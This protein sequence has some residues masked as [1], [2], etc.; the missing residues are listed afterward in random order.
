MTEHRVDVLLVEDDPG[1]VDLTREALK[2]GKLLINLETVEDGEKALAYL[3]REGPYGAV[4]RPDL[5]LLDLKLP[6]KDGLEVLREIKAD[7]AL[8]SI[9]VVVLT[10]S[11]AESDVVKS[12]GLGGNCYLTKPVGFEEFR[13]LVKQIKEFWFAVVKLPPQ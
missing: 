1:D 13:G 6:K 3:R 4:S 7:E 12:Y 8:Q 9:P 11:T 10:S 2:N 5:I